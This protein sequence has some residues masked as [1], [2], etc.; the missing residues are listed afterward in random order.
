MR[1]KITDQDLTDY[2]LNEL[3]AG[4]RLYVESML[5]VSEECLNDVYQM[6]EMSEMLKDG[7]EAEE[8]SASLLLNDEQRIKVLT[9]PRWQWRGLLQRAAAIALLLAG[10]GYAVKHP[11]VLHKGI[12][13][14]KAASASELTTGNAI[15]A[16]NKGFAKSAEEYIA[17]RMQAAKPQE[18]ADFQFVVAPAICTPPIFDMSV[19][20]DVLD[21]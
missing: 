15:D 5:S 11:E 3:G 20:S 6:L 16:G 9:V 19:V 14:R 7:F 13:V 4:E 1:G 18:G 17:A 12:A 8:D 21:M 10:A 2:A